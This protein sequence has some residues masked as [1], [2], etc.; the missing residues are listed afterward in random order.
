MHNGFHDL[1]G[2]APIMVVPDWS[3]PFEIMC[4]A[5]DFAVGAVLGQR[6]DQH[7]RPIYY[8][9]KTLNDAQENYT[10]TEKELLAVVFA[11]DKFHPY[12]VLS[13]VTVH[14][15]HSAIRYLMSKADAKPRLIRWILLLQEFDIE[16]RDKKGA[17]NVAADHLSRLDAPPADNLEE[18]INDS[19]PDERLMMMCLVESVTPWYSDFAN[20]LVGQ[21]LPKGMTTHAKRKFF[22]D[23]KYYFWDDPHLFRI[24]ADEIIC[25]CVME[26]EMEGILS[27]CHEGPAG[28]HHGGN[29]TA[30]KVLQS[31]F[32][33]PTLFKD[34]DAFAR[35]CDRCQRS[36][37]I[38][39][40]DEMPQNVFITCEIFDVWGIDFMGLFPPS[41]GNTYILVVVDYVSR[42]AEAQALPTNDARRVCGFL[43]QLF[44]R[45]GT[46]RAIISDRG[47][48]FQGQF[49]KLLS[50]YGVTHKV[51]VAYHPQTSGQAELTNRELKRILEKTVNISRKDWSTKLDDALWAYRTAYKTPIGTSLYRLVYGKA[52]HLP[53]E[54]EHKAFWALK[55]LNLD[56]SVAGVERKMQMLELEEWRYHAYENTKLYKERTKRLHDARLRCPKEFQVGDRVLLYNSRLKLFPGKLRSRWSGPYTVNQVFPYGTIEIANPQ[57]EPFKVNGHRLKLYLGDEVERAELA[58]ELADP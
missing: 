54:L 20:Y 23:L 46:P 32:Y 56:V 43:K 2:K 29:R 58:V 33:W 53:V 50:R 57:T 36:G 13:H 1:E 28:G 24:G 22:S 9:S 34:A 18:E 51:S 15:D 48:H 37:N 52:C 42:W 21:Q 49:D 14:T 44:S 7:F 11:F 41:F 47:T 16:I 4:D 19:F 40:R 38:S 55:L 35:R 27:H 17:E 3:L 31:G 45:F 6:R 10:T 39:A 26:S 30:R 5:S 12:L 8:A 25:R